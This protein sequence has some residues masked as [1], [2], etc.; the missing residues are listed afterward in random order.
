MREA[1][2]GGLGFRE[3]RVGEG[4]TE[5]ETRGGE[6]RTRLDQYTRL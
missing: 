6:Y 2:E 3:R 1:A 5:E 4:T